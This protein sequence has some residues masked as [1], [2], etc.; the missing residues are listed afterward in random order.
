MK[1]FLI[2]ALLVMPMTAFGASSVRVLG[3][4]AT[5]SAGVKTTTVSNAARIT[6]AKTTAAKTVAA[7]PSAASTASTSSTSPSSRIG[8]I[9][10]KPKTTTG[11][12][13]STTSS[14]GSRFPVITPAQSYKTVGSQQAAGGSSGGTAP[15]PAAVTD[16]PRFDMI[17]VDSRESYWRTNYPALTNQ[18][19]NEGYVFMWVE[20]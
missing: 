7:K 16:D 11:T 14:S 20:E 2:F 6:P 19:E 17:H 8:T 18:R 10:V 12:V 5:P 13:S 3:T 9:R 4:G 15:A 1:R